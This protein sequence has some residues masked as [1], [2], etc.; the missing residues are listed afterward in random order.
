[1]GH[2]DGYTLDDFEN[3][4][5]ACSKIEGKFLLSSYPSDILTEY[6]NKY[7]WKSEHYKAT[8][9]VGYSPNGKPKKPKVEVLTYNY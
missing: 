6:V 7:N 1:M 2:Y 4:L 9:S 8:V 3:L 5:K